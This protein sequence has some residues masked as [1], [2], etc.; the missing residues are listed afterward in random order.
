MNKRRLTPAAVC[1][2]AIRKEL[3]ETFPG[4]KFTVRS[5]NFAGGNSVDV[6]I[7]DTK[8]DCKKVDELL[9]KYEYGSFDGMTDMYNY[10][11]KRD[12]VPQ[13]KYVLSFLEI[14]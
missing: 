6:G 2:K 10:D 3:K 1:A 8:I 12:D 7:Y 4:S 13:V 14:D 5:R 11:N 9:A